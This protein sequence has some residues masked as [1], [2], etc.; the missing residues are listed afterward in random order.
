M[1]CAAAHPTLRGCPTVQVR[2]VGT[3]S[4]CPRRA[5][6]LPTLPTIG[7]RTSP[8]AD[9]PAGRE[10]RAYDRAEPRTPHFPHDRN[11]TREPRAPSKGC[12]T[13]R[14]QIHHGAER[15]G[16]GVKTVGC[17]TS[18]PPPVARKRWLNIIP[19]PGALKPWA[20]L[21]RIPPYA[22]ARPCK[23]V[24]WARFHRAHVG[25][26][27]PHPAHDPAEP[28]HPCA[29]PGPPW[30]NHGGPEKHPGP[31]CFNGEA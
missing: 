24:G 14:L 6:S 9:G 21:P 1:G 12:F 25:R 23:S 10:H 26:E 11:E 18:K 16:K 17:A 5:G 27:P 15:W 31:P 3:V 13:R 20:A 22:A 7:P 8:R 4:P 30:A 2:R 29:R 19:A 28:R